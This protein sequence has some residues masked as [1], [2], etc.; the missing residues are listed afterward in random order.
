MRRAAVLALVA[1]AVWCGWWLLRH[2]GA[3]ASSPTRP[4]VARPSG[5]HAASSDAGSADAAAE[6]GPH[7]RV[8]LGDE[9]TVRR[10]GPAA[11]AYSTRAAASLPAEALA[12]VDAASRRAGLELRVDAALARAAR[13]IASLASQLGEIPPEPALTFLLH[14][15]GAPDGGVG[16]HLQHAAPDDERALAQVL[17]AALARLPDGEGPVRLGVGEAMSDGP[18]GRT[19]AVVLGRVAFDVDGVATSARPGETWRLALTPARGWRDLEALALGEDGAL[20]DVPVRVSGGEARLELEVPAGARAGST[21]VVGVDGTGPHG[22]GKLAQLTVWIGEAPPASA[23]VQV[24][25]A[26]PA[27]LSLDGAERLALAYLAADRARAGKPALIADAALAAIARRHS[28]DMAARGYFGHASPTTGLA[29]DRLRAAGYLALAHGENLAKNDHLGEAEASLWESLGHRANIV[30]DAF[31]HV[32]IG[33]ARVPG[34]DGGWLVTQLFARPAP[35]V[36]AATADTLVAQINDDRAAA[37][38]RPLATRDALLELAEAAVARLAHE[39]LREVLG[40]VSRET[41]AAP[42]RAGLELGRHRRR[43]DRVRSPGLGAGE[44]DALDR[45]GGGAGSEKRRRERRG[46]RGGVGPT[47]PS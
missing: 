22:P 1:A 33:I 44:G 24:A 27:D 31:T 6:Q 43:R 30:G 19:T 21:I 16:V 26:E 20:H 10:L 29:G 28:D 4:S 32:G 23:A 2:D 37:G 12:L 25:A 5:E 40:D 46:D 3:P 8:H 42:A 35:A 34:D 7:G 47:R 15:S 9:L 41:H 14:S 38:A 36:S 18:L 39:P 45:P 11:T 17:E 13:E